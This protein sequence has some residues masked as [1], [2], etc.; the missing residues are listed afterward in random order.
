[1]TNINV[2][3]AHL[4]VNV[5]EWYW[6]EVWIPGRGYSRHSP[7]L[8]LLHSTYKDYRDELPSFTCDSFAW[9]VLSLD[10]PHFYNKYAVNDSERARSVNLQHV[11]KL[12]VGKPPVK[13]RRR[14]WWSWDRDRSQKWIKAYEPTLEEWQEKKEAR[15]AKVAWRAE[16]GK[17]KE[18]RKARHHRGPGRFWKG[19][20]SQR[21]RMWVQKNLYTE[22]YDAF[23]QGEREQFVD[24]WDWD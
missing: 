20:R 17:D 23:Y 3:Q 4:V 8:E 9:V 21:H 11:Y 24:R 2:R 12:I 15:E 10:R 1:M 16:S 6:K 7:H 13:V 18:R 5:Y 22:N 14:K 19:Q